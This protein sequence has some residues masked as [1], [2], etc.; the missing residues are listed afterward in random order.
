MDQRRNKIDNFQIRRRFDGNDDEIARPDFFR[1][2]VTVNSFNTEILAF[3]TD[4][5]SFAPHIIQ[6]SAHQKMHVVSGMGELCAV[7][8][9]DRTSADYPNTK[10]HLSN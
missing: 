10:P 2:I 8:G 3:A 9:S 5:N 4:K 7:I 1:R 6:T